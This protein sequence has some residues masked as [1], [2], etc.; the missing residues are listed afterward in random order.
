MAISWNHQAAGICIDCIKESWPRGKL[1][2]AGR[3]DD[4]KQSVM[5]RGVAAE[6]VTCQIPDQIAGYIVKR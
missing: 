2:R 1:T 4:V 3:L 5:Q 6:G